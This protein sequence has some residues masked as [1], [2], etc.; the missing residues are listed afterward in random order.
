MRD[1]EPNTVSG[2]VKCK[3]GAQLFGGN[4]I[5]GRLFLDSGVI[6]H[7]R[8]AVQSFSHTFVGSDTVVG[9]QSAF[10]N[11]IRFGSNNQ[12]GGDGIFNR[13]VT[14]RNVTIGPGCSLSGV[15]ENEVTIGD[16][17][18]TLRSVQLDEKTSLGDGVLLGQST[19]VLSGFHVGDNC[20][21]GD[22]VVVSSDV[23]VNSIWNDGEPIRKIVR[24]AGTTV[25]RV[26]GRCVEQ[27]R[28]RRLQPYVID[29]NVL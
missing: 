29:D 7:G 15:F 23:P 12:I 16:R 2:T 10:N 13:V 11:R 24:V 17:C 5:N 9:P 8:S 21:I 19:R 18:T 14:G 6:F 20:C 28:R 3:K 27:R 22:N 4:T 1:N 25:A 26:D